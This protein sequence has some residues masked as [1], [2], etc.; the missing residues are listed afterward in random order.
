MVFGSFASVLILFALPVTLLGCIAPFA[1]R[2]A[3]RDV[4]DAGH[5]AGRLYALSTL[6]SILG[7]FAPVLILIPSIGTART[8]LVFAGLLL[9]IAL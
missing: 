5:V 4:R 8:F 2:L 1:I 7:T 6:G 3:L 9:L